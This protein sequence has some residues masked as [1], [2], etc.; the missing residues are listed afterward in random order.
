MPLAPSM[1]VNLPGSS[2]SQNVNQPGPQMP[3]QEHSYLNRTHSPLLSESSDSS[4]SF[5]SLNFESRS[6]LGRPILPLRKSNTSPLSLMTNG[7]SNPR[8]PLPPSL[9][10]NVRNNMFHTRH[11][12]EIHTIPRLT[13]KPLLDS[14]IL[15][16]RSPSPASISRSN[17]SLSLIET[18]SIAELQQRKYANT[19]STSSSPLS[20]YNTV[21]TN[22]STYSSCNGSNYHNQ[23][24]SLSVCS[25]RVTKSPTPRRIFPQAASND[26]ALDLNQLNAREQAPVVFDANLTFVLGCDKQK[27]RQNFRPVAAHLDD[28]TASSYLSARIEDFLKRTDHVMDE[29]R[30]LG[31]K[32]DPEMNLQGSN[33]KR[34]GKSRSAAN[35]MIKGFQLYS[36]SGS[37]CRSSSYT[38]DFSEDRNTISEVDEV[39]HNKRSICLMFSYWMCCK[40]V[41]SNVHES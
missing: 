16:S 8:P 11:L 23:S 7:L 2:H 20:L 3:Y 10:Q 19:S 33:G 26:S 13:K 12:K 34:L 39:N 9:A 28:N 31:H 6:S 30:N 41:A 27:V 36:R 40:H 35:I 25:A 29:W 38:R 15:V 24:R 32:D 14:R 4:R 5:R 22:T 37:V 17:G 1:F 18:G 21:K